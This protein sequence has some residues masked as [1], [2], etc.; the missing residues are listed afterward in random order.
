VYGN[1]ADFLVGG[2]GLS[3][4]QARPDRDPYF[5]DCRDD[6]VGGTNRLG[7]LLKA[8]EE[9]VAGGIDLSTTEAV[10]FSANR[11]V[12]GCYKLLPRPVPESGGQLGRPH[13][14]REEDC[15]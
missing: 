4:M 6:R 1:P 7:R 15:R 5:G 12:V 14:I 10:Q 9:S 11:S 8:G 13:D 2:L 3:G